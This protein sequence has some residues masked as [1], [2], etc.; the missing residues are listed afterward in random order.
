[1]VDRYRKLRIVLYVAAAGCGLS[2]FGIVLPWNW[3]SGW[4]AAWGLGGIPPGPLAVYAI[5]TVSATFVFIGL[6]FLL[7]ARDPV[8]Y[9]PFL[10]LATAALLVIGLVCLIVGPSA[11][12][13][14]PWYL[15]DFV[16]CWVT[17]FLLV[18]WRRPR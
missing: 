9:A 2:V 5:R 11:G 1:M 7:I 3:L 14:P 17:G 10:N 6:F 15:V 4:T 13:R 16:F 12:M 18:A 8:T